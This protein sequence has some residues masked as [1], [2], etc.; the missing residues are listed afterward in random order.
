[1]QETLRTWNLLTGYWSGRIIVPLDAGTPFV[2][3]PTLLLKGSRASFQGKP[4]QRTS[5]F[6]LDCSRALWQTEGGTPT[7]WVPVALNLIALAPVPAEASH[8]LVM[9]GVLS[10]PT[11]ASDSSEITVD[12]GVLITLLDYARHLAVFKVGSETFEESKEARKRLWKAASEH[13]QH[14]QATALYRHVLG[15]PA[16]STEKPVWS[17]PSTPGAR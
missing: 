9:D 8:S 3:L 5:L 15:L 16:D 11:F 13:V 4:L 1:M 17:G 14:L 12:P 2:S 6:E 10:T 7:F